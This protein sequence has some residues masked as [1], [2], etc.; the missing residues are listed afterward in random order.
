MILAQAY[1]NT[2]VSSE[3]KNVQL[4]ARVHSTRVVLCFIHH[5]FGL[6][7]IVV[8]VCIWWCDVVRCTAINGIVALLKF[9][10]LIKLR[11]PKQ[12]QMNG[13]LKNWSSEAPTQ[14]KQKESRTRRKSIS[15]SSHRRIKRRKKRNNWFKNRT[16]N[17]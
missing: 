2:H 6:E 8:I 4:R 1:Q 7:L 12:K 5:C 14:K 3:E 16:K 11:K 13:K 15:P 9:T 10:W 17:K